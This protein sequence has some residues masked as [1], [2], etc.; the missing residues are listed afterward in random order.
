EISPNCRAISATSRGLD[1]RFPRLQSRVTLKR[2]SSA[3]GTSTTRHVPFFFRRWKALLIVALVC[4][5]LYFGVREFQKWREYAVL[6]QALAETD[7]LDPGWRFEEM[8]ANLPKLDPAQ[9]GTHRLLETARRLATGF[10]SW[11]GLKFPGQTADTP[12]ER[13]KDATEDFDYK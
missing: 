12:S 3:N 4:V 1:C 5:G 10:P 11:K 7:R 6:A 13:L 9:N 2:M 8:E